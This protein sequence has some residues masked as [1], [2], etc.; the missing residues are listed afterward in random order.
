MKRGALIAILFLRALAAPAQQPTAAPENP[1]DAPATTLKVDVKLVNVY[2]SVLDA[3]GSPVAGLTRDNFR[4][5]EDDEPQK[6]AVFDREAEQPLSI[7]LAIDTSLSTRK[8]I[9]LELESARRFVHT[10]L[11]PV[12]RLS[13]YQFDEVVK[14]MV[15][16][17]ADLKAIDRGIDGVRVGSATAVF[18]AVYLGS[19]A[20][21]GRR[22]RKVLVIVTDGGDTASQVDYL[23]A[24]REALTAEALVYS[25]IIVPIASS[26]GRNTGGEHA[27]IQLSKDTGGKYFYADTTARL[28][29]VFHKIDEELR[30]QYLLGYYPSRRVSD[31][32]FRRIEVKVT[33]PAGSGEMTARHRTGYFTNPSK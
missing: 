2:V 32:E 21:S 13:L 7:V 3:N 31:S 8:D 9:R 1:Q 28:D 24:R 26:A 22:G 16:F 11:R 30:T 10:I 6:I 20:L 19:E 5:A 33:P 14:E 18:D 12:D 29:E 17:T 15:P 23:E 4:L 27:L 25:V